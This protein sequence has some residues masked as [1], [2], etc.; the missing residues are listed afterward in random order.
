MSKLSKHMLSTMHKNPPIP[1]VTK[2]KKVETEGAD[3]DKVESNRLE[4][5]VDSFNPTT[6][7]PKEF[8]IVKNRSSE[9][10]IRWLIGYCDLELLMPLKEPLDQTKVLCTMLKGQALSFF[11][12]HLS[13]CCV[14]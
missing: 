3:S 5:L 9:E 11:E 6:Q 4:F 14:F 10:H 8:L 2:L 7:F 13:K 1:F 12:C